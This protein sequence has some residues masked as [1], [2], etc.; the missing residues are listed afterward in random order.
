VA[1]GRTPSPSFPGLMSSLIL[2]LGNS[3]IHQVQTY[4]IYGIPST[5]FISVFWH[6]ALSE[7]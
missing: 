6:L 3:I 2:E 5:K 7:K 4:T 1:F